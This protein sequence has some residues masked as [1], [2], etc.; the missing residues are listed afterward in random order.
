MTQ[1][2]TQEPQEQTRSKIIEGRTNSSIYLHVGPKYAN[3]NEWKPAVG[4]KICIDH[5]ELE[6]IVYID[7]PLI[8]TAFKPIE[9]SIL[10]RLYSVQEDSSSTDVIEISRIRED[11][12]IRGLDSSYEELE[13]VM[14]GKR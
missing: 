10:L 9:N 7:L 4:N 14:E 11:R 13:R 8:K 3:N 2:A 6:S 1:T 12:I 5:G